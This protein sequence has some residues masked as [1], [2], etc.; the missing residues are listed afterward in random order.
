MSGY[1][2]EPHDCPANGHDESSG[3]RRPHVFQRLPVKHSIQDR[4]ITWVRVR[5]MS[6][7]YLEQLRSDASSHIP[8]DR[9]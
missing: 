5:R 9:G 4:R 6:L 3:S 7:I 8:D 2:T 1:G